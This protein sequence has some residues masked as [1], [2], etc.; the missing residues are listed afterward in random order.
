MTS[1]KLKT[2]SRSQ[3]RR[4]LLYIFSFQN[5]MRGT[6]IR[7]IT[8]TQCGILPVYSLLLPLDCL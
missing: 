6:T 4:E 2:T 1:E 3:R 7:M 8:K 5:G